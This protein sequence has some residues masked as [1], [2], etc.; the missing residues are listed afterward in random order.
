M[1][2]FHGSVLRSLE[3]DDRE[4]IQKYGGQ[5]LL[6]RNLTQRILIL[7]GVANASKGAFGQTTRGVIGPSN[8]YEL[9]TE[10]L[11]ERLEIGRMTG[12]TLLLGADVRADFLSTKGANRLKAL[13]GGDTLE[14]ERKGSNKQYSIDG[15]FNVIITAISQLRVRLEGDLGAWERR[16]SIVQYDRPYEGKKIPDVHRLLLETEATGILNFYIEGAQK[17]LREINEL[18][19]TVLAIVRKKE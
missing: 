13:V 14:A 15:I 16:I 8:C 3:P 19:D 5:C 12:K 17:L 11:A 6:G 1:P 4:L 9:R 7:D 18:G 2:K 10:H